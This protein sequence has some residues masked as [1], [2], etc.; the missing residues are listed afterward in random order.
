MAGLVCLLLGT[1]A[2]LAHQ[3]P[4]GCTGSGLGISLFADKPDVKLGDTISY[5]VLVFVTAFPACDATGIQ[6]SI[7]TP[8][9]VTHPITLRRT[10]LVPGDSDYYDSVVTYVV[11]AQDVPAGNV[12]R[13]TAADSGDI[14][15]N[16]PDSR[17]GGFQGVDTTLAV[18]CLQVTA[19]CTGSVGETGTITF[20]GTVKNCGNIALSGVTVSNNVNNTSFLV[21]GPINLATNQTVSFAG[22]WIP[23]NPC[24]PSTATIVVQGSDTSS[25]SPITARASTTTTCSDVLTPSIQVTK[26]CPPGP[27]APGQALVYSG[28]VTNTGNVTLTNVVVVSDQPAANTVVF[29]AASLAPGAGAAFTGTYTA[30]VTCSTTSALVAR[31][32]S[33][34]GVP[35]SST[36][37]STCPILTAPSILVTA[38]CS[39]NTVAPGGV[40]TYSGSVANTGNIP[41][42]NVVVVS[43]RP[44]PNTPIFTAATLAPG[45]SAKFTGSYTVPANNTC[46]VTTTI[47][48]TGKDVCTGN[49][50]TNTTAIT[51]T[52]TTTPAIVVSLS[53]PAVPVA[54][55]ASITYSGTVRNSGNV[56]LN[57]VVVVN[58]AL[59]T[60][61]LTVASLAPGASANFTSTFTTPA[62]ACSVSSTVTASGSDACTSALVSNS[63]SATCPLVT[64]PRITVTQNCP[65]SPVSPNGVLTYSGTVNNTGNVTLTNV[66]VLNDHSGATPVFT[67]ATLAPGATASFTGSYTVPANSGCSITSTLSASG[68]DKCT[69]TRVSATAS[70]TCP[71]VTAPEIEVIQFCPSAPVLQGGVLT[72]SGIVSNAGNITLTNVVVLNDRT[73]TRPVFTAATFAPGAVANFTGSY[74]VPVNCCSVSSTVTA[75]GRDACTGALVTDTHTTTCPVLTAPRI[76]VTKVCPTKTL[77]PGDLLKYSGSVSNAGNIALTNVVVINVYNQFNQAAVQTQLL[78][79]ITLAPGESVN[80]TAS[81]TVPIDFCGNDTVT[82][83]G[84]DTCT[85]I[86]VSHTLTT[87]CPVVTTP[88]IGVTK[89]CPV[90]PTPRGGLYVF[91]GTVTNTG[92]VTL[93][94]VFV[95]DNQP[96]NNTPVIGPISLAPGAWTNFSGSYIA[97]VDCCQISDTLTA[98][99]QDRCSGAPVRATA[100]A[101]CPLLTTPR[102]TVTRVCPSSSVPVGGLFVF[103]GSVSN[104]GDV[105]LTNVMVL[106]NQ[107]N[108]NTPLLGPIEL[109][110]GESEDFNGSYIVAAGSDPSVDIVTA[111]GTDTCQARTVTARANCSGP[112]SQ[113]SSSLI[114]SVISVNGVATVSWTAMPG[115]TYCIQYKSSIADSSWVTIPGNVTAT[116]VKAS[117]SDAAAAGKQRIY[118]VMIVQ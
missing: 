17:G 83:S 114:A 88:G 66:V 7:V 90:S 70:S 28:T 19:V 38:V 85:G 39:T 98:T 51:C 69:G 77:L 11:R 37:S 97:P 91:T 29:T 43:D 87:T 56:T 58:P 15:Q 68:N 115:V 50:V 13:A 80:Y 55:G 100:S 6:A 59:T 103:S 101:V 36:A 18:P 113:S 96:A 25:T 14:H 102:I 93:N 16:N 106:S 108:N 41:L 57:N 105:T 78:G 1:S 74:V 81:Y 5:S 110:P 60:T 99:G 27:L 109:A 92:N 73:G 12:L 53:C 65:V 75:S 52:A 42:N 71:L 31:G 40:L 44:A 8:D 22:S 26:V 82:A 72:Y 111:S 48:G 10:S 64:A 54:T 9:G 86:N 33:I 20:T 107:P 76:V 46:A 118:R 63:A 89:V 21:L 95:V 34:C 2:V 3:S 61:V 112:L 117:K 116:G 24:L 35:V 47:S 94:N 49:G 32:T 84:F 45:A 79:P 67:V 30:P 104:T 23:A 4:P 62:D